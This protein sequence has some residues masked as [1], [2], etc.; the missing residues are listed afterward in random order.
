M[1]P[2]FDDKRSFVHPALGF[3]IGLL[4]K[5]LSYFFALYFALYQVAESEPKA[6]SIGDIFE[7]SIGWFAARLLI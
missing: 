1:I 5:K 3:G 7:F 6:N 2:F 4:N